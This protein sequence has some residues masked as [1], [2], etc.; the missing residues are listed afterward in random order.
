[1]DC[2]YVQEDVS[3][4]HDGGDAQ[5]ICAHDHGACGCQSEFVVPGGSSESSSEHGVDLQAAAH[6][7][8]AAAAAITVPDVPV[9]GQQ[10]AA[11]VSVVQRLF[12]YV[13]S[14]RKPKRPRLQS[15]NKDGTV[16]KPYSSNKRRTLNYTK[17][18]GGRAKRVFKAV[19]Q[20][21][22]CVGIGC[23]YGE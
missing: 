14:N 4:E 5:P 21:H 17:S 11:E 13:K 1:M 22:M 19:A 6:A 3:W 12:A 18:D 2:M 23:D 20:M 9:V 8:A 15:Y 10:D 7:A 16:R